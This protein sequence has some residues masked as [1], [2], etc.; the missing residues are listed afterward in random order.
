[1]NRQNIDLDDLRSRWQQTDSRLSALEEQTGRLSADID[2][3]RRTTALRSLSDRYR[4]F[5][6]VGMAMAPCWWLTALNLH[7]Y[8][9]SAAN[10]A[11]GLA[12]AVFF[13]LAA[14]LDFVLQSR[15]NSID[16][17]SQSVGE[18]YGKIMKSRRLHHISMLIL[19]PFALTLIGFF[20]YGGRDNTYLLAGIICGFLLGLVIGIRKYLQFM[21]D[22]RA[23]TA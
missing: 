4:R 2:S 18:V 20:A 8:E 11:L 15:I 17:L 23:A 7:L 14:A 21:R 22:Y 19:M 1:M 5:A 16:V 6:I 9:S 13:C 12:G 3:R 10:F